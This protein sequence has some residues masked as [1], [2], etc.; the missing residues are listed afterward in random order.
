MT[1]E[2]RLDCQLLPPRQVHVEERTVQEHRLHLA[3]AG[4]PVGIQRGDEAT[5]GVAVE[6]QPVDPLLGLQQ[7][8]RRRHV[9]EVLVDRAREVRHLP[10]AQR[11]PVATKIE[12][13]EAQPVR[14]V[15]LGEVRL[16]E[17][18]DEAVHVQH[19]RPTTAR[20]AGPSHHDGIRAAARAR[21]R[22]GGVL[23]PVEHIG[24]PHGALRIAAVVRTAHRAGPSVGVGGCAAT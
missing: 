9:V 15:E 8:D 23:E 5:S 10:V 19:R 22:Q 20:R 24:L 2:H 3:A 6:Q 14:L 11:P 1:N 18:V 21:H 12:R 4:A 13:V 17:V 16:E 7:A